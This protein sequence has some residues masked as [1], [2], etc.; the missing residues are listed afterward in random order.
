MASPYLYHDTETPA[1]VRELLSGAVISTVSLS[2]CQCSKSQMVRY[3]MVS[4]CADF[5]SFLCCGV[6]FQ[7]NTAKVRN[8]F[9]RSAVVTTR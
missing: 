8:V 7:G 3:E 5:S 6:V 4:R 1:D 9:Q 2:G